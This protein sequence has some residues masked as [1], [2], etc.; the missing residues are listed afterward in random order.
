MDGWMDG[1]MDCDFT[2]SV[3]NSTSVACI[4]GQLEGDYETL[5]KIFKKKNPPQGAGNSTREASA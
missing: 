2:S 1:W 3:F 4:S 5:C